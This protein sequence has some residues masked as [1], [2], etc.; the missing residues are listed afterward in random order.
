MN[1]KEIFIKALH[2]V[3]CFNHIIDKLEDIGLTVEDNAFGGALYNGYDGPTAIAMDCLSFDS[4][5]IENDIY[6]KIISIK[7]DEYEEFAEE[8]WTEYG[9]TRN[10]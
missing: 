8:V 6:N 10:I 4:I 5:G 2:A 7:L 1:K 9:D 3:A